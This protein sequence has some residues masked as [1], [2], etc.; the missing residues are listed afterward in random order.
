MVGAGGRRIKYP[1]TNVFWNVTELLP[2]LLLSMKLGNSHED[3][4]PDATHAVVSKC[5]VDLS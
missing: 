3:K 5:L 1:P 4:Y 2:A